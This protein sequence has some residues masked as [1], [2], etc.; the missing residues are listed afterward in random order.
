MKFDIGML[1]NIV[2]KGENAGYQHFVLFS[3][4]EHNVL[5]VSYCD[6]SM[7]DVRP[8]VW[9]SVRPNNYLKNLLL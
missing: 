7:S 8:S 1:E 5:R 2:R 3:S 4:P 6:R 9:P